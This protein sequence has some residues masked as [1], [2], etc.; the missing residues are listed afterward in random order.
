MI[1]RCNAVY[2]SVTNGEL[3]HRERPL[4]FMQNG[5]PHCKMVYTKLQYLLFSNF[6]LVL[7][8]FFARKKSGY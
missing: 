1:V 3:M 7:T 5:A 4:D 2:L 6:V 8:R